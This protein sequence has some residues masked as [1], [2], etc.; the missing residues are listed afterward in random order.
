[1][2]IFAR[3]FSEK[4]NDV[5]VEELTAWHLRSLIKSQKLFADGVPEEATFI[6]FTTAG[7]ALFDTVN[8]VDSEGDVMRD[9]FMVHPQTREILNFWM[10]EAA[11]NDKGW[12]GVKCLQMLPNMHT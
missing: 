7:W 1:M 12:R 2:N 8:T 9:E 4:F 10:Y 5:R 6:G 3:L 11:T